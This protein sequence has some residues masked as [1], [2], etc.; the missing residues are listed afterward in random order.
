MNSYHQEP[1]IRTYGVMKE[2]KRVC[3]VM[4]EKYDLSLRETP[5]EIDPEIDS[6][7]IH[8]FVVSNLYSI[9]VSDPVEVLEQVNTVA[10]GPKEEVLRKLGLLAYDEFLQRQDKKVSSYLGG[11]IVVAKTIDGVT[12]KINE[13]DERGIDGPMTRSAAAGTFHRV[14]TDQNRIILSESKQQYWS[15]DMSKLDSERLPRGLRIVDF[16]Q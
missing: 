3:G 2:T 15:V 13:A 10:D 8:D 4:A 14:F 6:V 7:A 16:D 12:P 1:I 11:K 9:L 5:P